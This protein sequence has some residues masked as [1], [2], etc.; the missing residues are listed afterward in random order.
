MTLYAVI[1]DRHG[2]REHSRYAVLDDAVLVA[3]GLRIE[4]GH[5]VRV[6]REV[7]R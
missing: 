2:W 1:I 7:E 5:A 6:C 3:R 4:H